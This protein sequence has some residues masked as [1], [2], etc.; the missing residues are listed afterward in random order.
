VQIIFASLNQKGRAAIVLDT[1]AASRGSGSAN[2]SKE[3]DVRRWFVE[4]D[5]IEGV[6]YLPED[7]FYNT[8]SPGIIIVLNRAK[9]KARE[10]KLFL[11]NASLEFV[12]GEP[13][14]Y[15]PEEAIARIAGTFSAWKEIERYSRVVTR[16]EI[17]KNDFD[18]SPSRYIHTGEGKEYRSVA[19]IMEELAAIEE[20]AR[21]TAVTLKTVLSKIG[22]R[23]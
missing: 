17:K 22:L 1:G 15:I 7:L 10:G 11:L 16:D 12:K 5:V 21:T 2:R 18:I 13:K 20:E 6:I 3:R 19:E 9:P 14:N 8:P 23:V 4:N